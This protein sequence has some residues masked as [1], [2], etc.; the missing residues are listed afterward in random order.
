M[1]ICCD[2]G[3]S[4]VRFALIDPE[5]RVRQLASYGASEFAGGAGG[6]ASSIAK[7][8]ND[9]RSTFELGE[10]TEFVVGAAGPVSQGKVIFT[11]SDW[12]IDIE[13]IKINF[14]K[15]FSS[16]CLFG[17]INDFE[18]LAYGLAL[19]QSDEREIL[20]GLQGRGGMRM[21]CGPGTGLGLAGLKLIGPSKLHVIAVP[22][23]GGHQSFADETPIEREL[24]DY[25]PGFVS[26]EDFLSG[27]GLKTIY[28]F[29]CERSGNPN[30]I[31]IDPPQIIGEFALGNQAARLT[32]ETFASILGA[33]CG[34]AALA[35]GAQEGVYLWGG[36]LK[37]F[38]SEVLIKNMMQRFHNRGK[39]SD[40]LADVPVYK[41]TGNEIAL[42]GCALFG[43]N[44]GSGIPSSDGTLRF[45]NR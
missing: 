35:L 9:I 45:I 21:V 33:F 12:V 17:L 1:R 4:T 19:I 11:N 41:I 40:Y 29:H 31:E 36:I 27:A 16:D 28:N 22:T 24:R 32:L 39:R 3:G 13:D 18:A 23:E 10:V 14:R 6:F 5:F 20:F 42:K 7:F 30:K 2:A 38:P 34:N 44:L 37:D 15:E 8:L 26:Y 25:L 43:R